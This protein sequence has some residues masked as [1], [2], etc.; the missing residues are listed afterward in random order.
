MPF[1]NQCGTELPEGSKFCGVCGASVQSGGESADTG[2][3]H[4]L[5]ISR[6]SQFV[7]ALTSYEAY[8]DGSVLG[9]IPV[10][11][12]IA[13]RVFSDVVKVEIKCTTIMMKR[14]KVGFLL[15]LHQ[16]P[17]VDF[18]LNYPGTIIYNVSGADILEVYE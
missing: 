2:V 9:N 3:V 13:A 18:K 17:R 7:C 12:S 5:V 10:G 8:I 16:N 4:T 6:A 1:C 14:F 11:Q 15:R